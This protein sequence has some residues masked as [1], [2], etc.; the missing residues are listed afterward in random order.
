[1]ALPGDEEVP[2]MDAP[3]IIGGTFGSCLEEEV[4]DFCSSMEDVRESDSTAFASFIR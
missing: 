1:M 3:P 4:E 2:D